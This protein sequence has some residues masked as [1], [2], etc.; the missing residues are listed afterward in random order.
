M[1]TTELGIVTVESKVHRRNA[2]WPMVVTES[3]IKT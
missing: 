3:G 2:L 1:V